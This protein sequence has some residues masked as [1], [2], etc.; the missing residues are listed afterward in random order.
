MTKMG[1]PGTGR[2]CLHLG[3]CADYF[4]VPCSGPSTVTNA[5]PRF[6]IRYSIKH[7]MLSI[8]S[9]SGIIDV[10]GPEATRGTADFCL[11]TDLVLSSAGGI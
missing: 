4:R 11:T 3:V 5:S 8:F 1:L 6:V 7:K 10:R 9:G 2:D